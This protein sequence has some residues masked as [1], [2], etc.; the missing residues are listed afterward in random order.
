MKRAT[1]TLYI[2]DVPTDVA[3]R[4]DTQAK[5]GGF[6]SRQ[7]FLLAK[8]TELSLEE[9]QLVTEQRYQWILKEMRKL[10]EHNTSALTK[11]EELY[12]IILT[13]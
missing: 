13:E 5:Q 7:T 2:R 10:V 9:L 3:H 8:L 12:E 6:K 1:K 4:L 11:V